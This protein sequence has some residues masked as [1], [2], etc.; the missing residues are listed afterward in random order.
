[1]KYLLLICLMGVIYNLTFV[2]IL[3]TKNRKSTI[4]FK[5]I[6]FLIGLAQMTL[7]LKGYGI[8]NI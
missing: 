7:V 3:T 2:V 4:L 5:I 1:M 8:L 6:P